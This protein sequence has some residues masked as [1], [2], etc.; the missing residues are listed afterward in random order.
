MAGADNVRNW[1]LRQHTNSSPAAA[2]PAKPVSSCFVSSF[3]LL[4]DFGG[5]GDVRHFPLRVMVVFISTN[6]SMRISCILYSHVFP[7]SEFRIRKQTKTGWL[8]G[9]ELGFRILST[10]LT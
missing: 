9:T 4:T 3:S 5:H 10:L 2:A 8:G 7:F 6:K 1:Y